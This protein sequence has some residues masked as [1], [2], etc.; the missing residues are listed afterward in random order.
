VPDQEQLIQVGI[1]WRH[2]GIGDGKIGLRL[3]AGG[4][5]NLLFS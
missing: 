5:S 3:E 4:W 1:D 2:P